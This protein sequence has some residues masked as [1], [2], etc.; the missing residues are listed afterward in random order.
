MRTLLLTAHYVSLG[1]PCSL[2][3]FTIALLL[4][5]VMKRRFNVIQVGG[6]RGE[7][8]ALGKGGGYVA[9]A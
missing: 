5:V 1:M 6:R 7:G 4:R 8:A 3:V 9:Q 2:Q